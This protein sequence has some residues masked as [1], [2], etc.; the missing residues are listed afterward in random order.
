MVVGLIQARHVGFHGEA[1]DVDV[2]PGH[3]VGGQDL[4]QLLEVAGADGG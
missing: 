3:E 1:D 4:E 2:E